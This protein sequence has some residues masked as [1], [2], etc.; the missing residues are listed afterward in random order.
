MQLLNCQKKP[1]KY[2]KKWQDDTYNPICTTAHMPHQFTSIFKPI[3]TSY[4]IL[5][6]YLYY[7][8]TYLLICLLQ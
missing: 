3:I 6:R 2:R 7:I 4:Y 1:S 5:W 8:P